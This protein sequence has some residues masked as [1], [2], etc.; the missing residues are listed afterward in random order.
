MYIADHIICAGNVEVAHV[1]VRYNVGRILVSYRGGLLLCQ[2]H[3]WSRVSWKRGGGPGR[4]RKCHLK[5]AR[6]I[7]DGRYTLIHD[8]IETMR[9]GSK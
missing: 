6:C 7:T 4:S 3:S 9:T 2:I 5:E 8:Y 1:L